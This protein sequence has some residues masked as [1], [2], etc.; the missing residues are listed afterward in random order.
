MSVSTR[1]KELTALTLVFI[2]TCSSTLLASTAEY[3]DAIAQLAKASY[4]HMQVAY[5]CRSVVWARHLVEARIATE[6]ALRATGLPTAMAF[7][8]AEE[9]AVSAAAASKNRPMTT[10]S[11]C[12]SK[13]AT[14]RKAVLRWRQLAL[15][16]SR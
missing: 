13:L 14:T 3:E 7:K 15:S 6:N 10:I 8:S 11:E 2:T 1:Y 12:T 16:A 4:E 5:S 9:I